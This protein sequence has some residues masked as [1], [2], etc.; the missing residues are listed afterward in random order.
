LA[1]KKQEKR[2]HEP[3][4]RQRSHLKQQ[5]R[6]QRIILGLAILVVVAVLSV[7]GIGVYNGWYVEDYKPLHETVLEVNGTKFNMEYYVTMLDYYTQDLDPIYI[8]YMTDYTA[9]AIERNELVKQAAAALDI[10]VSDEEVDELMESLDLPQEKPYRDL[11]ITQL[12]LQKVRDEYLEEQVPKFADQRHIMAMFL[13]SEAQANEVIA[14]IEAGE[15][16]TELAA[17]LSLDDVTKEA[18]GDLG[19]LPQGILPLTVDSEVLEENAFTI[20]VGTLSQPI[21]EAD[22]T[23]SVGYWLVEV[24]EITE[25]DEGDEEGGSVE[26]Q[27]KR[28]L[29]G[30]EQE[31]LDITARLEAGEDFAELAAE[32]SLDTVSNTTGGEI[33]VSP[34]TNTAAFDDYVFGEDVELGV[35]SPP[36]RDTE[37]SSTGGYWLIEVTEAEA[38]RE[39]DDDNRLILKNDALNNWLEG[40]KDDPDN[41]IDNYLDE[42]KLYWAVQ[43]VLGG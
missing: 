13:E 4:R 25:A 7:V 8:S 38:N 33:T 14:R 3:T 26:A 36:I 12:L 16:F 39:I 10:T 1:K 9:E 18:E 41:V 15:S 19:W 6:R 34:D 35:L 32:Y 5:K 22:K 21:F 29:L 17:E 37:V 23:K 11:A 30:S 20:E 27:V 43:Y 31:A 2:R 40:L 24:I 42:D 28:M